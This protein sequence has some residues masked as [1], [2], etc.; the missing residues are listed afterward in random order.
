MTAVKASLS[1]MNHSFS[2]LFRAW[3]NRLWTFNWFLTLT[4][5]LF[6]VAIPFYV[7]AAILDP[8][9][10]TNAPAFVKP[11]KFVVSIAIYLGT[12]LFLLTLVQRRRWWVHFVGNVTALGLLIEIVLITMQAIRG[13]TSHYNQTTP[14]DAMVFNMMGSAI[15]IVA[16][17]NLV[18]GIWLLF[19]RLPDPTIAWGLRLGVL[20]SLLGMLV[21]FRMTGT[22]SPA[23]LAQMRAGQEPT[24]IGAH[25]VGIEDGGPG[26]PFVGWSTVGGDLRVP[27]FVGLHSMQILP[28]LGFTL[29]RRR[30]LAQRQRLVLIL[31]AGLG[32]LGWLVL[33][34]WQAL[35]G[36][37]VVAPDLLTLTAYAVLLGIVALGTA[38]ALT[39]QR[40]SNP[41]TVHAQ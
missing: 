8:R 28:L 13:T 7:V 41:A 31:T 18:L 12:F 34:T 4:V 3:F 30:T 19:Q 35:R 29:S 24:A 20:I 38:L 40:P 2:S 32:Y 11:L 9:L 36:Q 16:V 17:L 22:P 5:L 33:L 37:S 10:I 39:R 26:L 1:Q 21:A 23:Q 15:V 14:F 25:S 6:V 27:H